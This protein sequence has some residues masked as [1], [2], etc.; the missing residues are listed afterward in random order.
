MRK[1][2]FA[3]IACV[4]LSFFIPNSI[5]SKLSSSDIARINEAY[6]IIDDSYLHESL[7]KKILINGAIEGMLQAVDQNSGYYD[8]DDYAYFKDYSDGKFGGIGIT[9][10][11]EGEK[12]IVASVIKNEPAD[13]VGI[14]AGDVIISIDDVGI[15]GLN[16]IKI[17]NLIRGKPGTTVK[18]TIDRA[19]EVF[20]LTIQRKELKI[21]AVKYKDIKNVAVFT[22][23]SFNQQT[24]SQFLSLATA[25]ILPKNASGIILDLRGN[26]GGILDQAVDIANLFLQNYVKI[27]TVKGKG[28]EIREEYIANDLPDMVNGIPILIIVDKDTASAAEVLAA[29]LRDNKRAIIVGEKTFGKATVQSFFDLSRSPGSAIKLTVGKYVTPLNIEIDKIG[30]VPDINLNKK[31]EIDWIEQAVDIVLDNNGYKKLIKNS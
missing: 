8:E 12:T 13:L 26:P 24:Y 5:A 28:G 16:P 29:A 11:K 30:I 2:Y 9:H 23:P 27:V 10:I 25:N 7:D 3:L 31:P 15:S 21:D 6:S 19:G 20:N 22:I 1:A 17:A 14:K 4:F 18:L